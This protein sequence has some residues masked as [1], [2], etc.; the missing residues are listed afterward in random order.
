MSYNVMSKYDAHTIRAVFVRGMCGFYDNQDWC[1]CWEDVC[2]GIRKLT[3][4]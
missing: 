1:D 4:T 2:F 3:V